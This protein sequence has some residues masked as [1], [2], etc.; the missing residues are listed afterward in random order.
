[1]EPIEVLLV[2]SSAGDTLLTS[3][4]LAKCPTPVN[5]HVARDGLEAIL[6]LS[7]GT[8][9]PHLVILELSIPGISG[10]DVLERY[11]PKEVPVVVFSSSRNKANE[12]RAFALGAREYIQKPKDLDGFRDAV[13]GIIKRWGRRGES[14]AARGATTF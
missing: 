8:F 7:R 5:L 12:R 9:H 1:M 2:E 6:I 14:D 10:Y 13:L 11:H 4:I 3:Q